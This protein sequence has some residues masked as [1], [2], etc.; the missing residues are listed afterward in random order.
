MLNIF[1]VHFAEA[2]YWVL[3]P[4][5]FLVLILL[6]INC[7]KIK[8]FSKMLVSTNNKSKMLKNFSIFRLYLKVIFTSIALFLIIL[9][10]LRPQWGKKE[11]KVEQVGRDVLIVLDISR[12][13]LAKD[14]KPSRLEFAKLKIRNLLSKFDFERVGLIIF[15]GDAFVQCPM[16]SDYSAFLLFLDQVDRQ[17][18]SS[19]TTSLDKAFL[20][21]KDVFL[22]SEDRKNKLVVLLSDGEDFSLNLP[23][24]KSWA[25]K[26]D[27]KIFGLGIGSPQGAPIPVLDDEGSQ[28][29]HEIDENGKPILSVL[30]EKLLS[31]ICNDL[32]GMYVRS[33]YDDSDLD[34][35]VA[36]IQQFE[37]EKFDERKISHFKERYPWFL[38]VA[39]FLLLFEWIL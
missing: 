4:V 33:V 37:K 10:I 39:W 2:Q 23:K 24:A 8:N 17:T 25:K 12:S 34:K 11:E 19:G 21:T 9:A 28:V 35:I 3:F 20:K 22:S 14:L 7:R 13:M 18:I 36:R 26:E 6:I 31:S 5:L 15:S 32:G 29:G 16:T 38:G 27:I 30:N 1:G